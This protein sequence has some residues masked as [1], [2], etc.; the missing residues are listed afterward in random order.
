VFG[1]VRQPVQ[2][3]LCVCGVELVGDV[4]RALA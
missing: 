4:L 3:R 2:A 1:L